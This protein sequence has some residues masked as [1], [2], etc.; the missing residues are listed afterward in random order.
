MLEKLQEVYEGIKISYKYHS[1]GQFSV[2]KSSFELYMSKM[3]DET[4]KKTQL[5][6]KFNE[7]S[8]SI[9]K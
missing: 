5:D 3:I 6:K 7:V 4:Y 1:A 9:P 2:N 8:S